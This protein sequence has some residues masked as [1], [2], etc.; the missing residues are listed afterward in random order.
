MSSS[1]GSSSFGSGNPRP[2]NGSGRFA[3]ARNKKYILF[4]GNPGTGKSTMANSLIGQVAFRSDVS[5]GTGVTTRLDSHTIRDGTTFLDT[6]GLDDIQRR[7]QA[8]AQIKEGLMQGGEYRI[9]FVLTLEGGRVR[10]ADIATM[11][12]ILNAIREPQIRYSIIINQVTKRVRMMLDVEE[13]YTKLFALINSEEYPTESIF[14]N[15][16][17]PGLVDRANALVNA[18]TELRSF[19]EAAPRFSI[20]PSHVESLDLRK[21]EEYQNE[22]EELTKNN[23]LL[24]ERFDNITQQLSQQQTNMNTLGTQLRA[25]QQA[26]QELARHHELELQFANLQLSELAS[27]LSSANERASEAHEQARSARVEA[28][29]AVSRSQSVE[30]AAQSLRW[31]LEAASERQSYGSPQ[32]MFRRPFISP[33]RLYEHLLPTPSPRAPSSPG[34]RSFGTSSPSWNGFGDDSDDDSDDDDGRCHAII[35]YGPNAGERCSFKARSRGFCG[36]HGG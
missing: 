13:N 16:F 23:Q 26:H 29:R 8:A 31:Q 9:F 10:P 24:Q 28:Q 22:V 14:F 32:P 11:R 4:V 30:A 1:S 25:S 18:S 21:I 17:D 34:L 33:E 19:I 20:D 36:H 3:P 12:T 2:S 7:E 6:P 35:R 27:Q 5:I 15:D